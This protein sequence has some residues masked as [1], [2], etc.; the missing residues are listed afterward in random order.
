[1]ESFVSDPPLHSEFDEIILCGVPKVYVDNILDACNNYFGTHTEHSL[2]NFE[3]K[4][5]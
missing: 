2:T 5:R 1:M 4:P 3:T